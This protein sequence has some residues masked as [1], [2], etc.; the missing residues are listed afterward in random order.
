[1][2]PP[3]ICFPSLFLILFSYLVIGQSITLENVM[4]PIKVQSGKHTYHGG[5]CEGE[6][7]LYT[8]IK[9]AP[10]LPKTTNQWS[11]TTS[12]NF[13]LSVSGRNPKRRFLFINMY[14]ITQY[15]LKIHVPHLG[16]LLLAH[17]FSCR[18]F[19]ISL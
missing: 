3:I 11:T 5:F 19:L 14:C 17:S 10:K 4:T 7:P 9:N 1:M 2:N 15:S 6:N 18:Y 16:F 8:K 12:I 13:R